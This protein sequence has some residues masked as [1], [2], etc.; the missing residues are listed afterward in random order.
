MK[1]AQLQ[2]SNQALRLDT[3]DFTILPDSIEGRVKL[4]LENIRGPQKHRLIKY[5]SSHPNVWTHDLAANCAV[6]FPPNRLGELNKEVLPRFGLLA[7][8][9]RP[10]DWLMNRHGEKSYV[11]QWRLVKLPTKKRGTA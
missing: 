3:S 1:K 9:R 10:K 7:I 2:K 6:G 8:C 4:A 11:Q 5:L